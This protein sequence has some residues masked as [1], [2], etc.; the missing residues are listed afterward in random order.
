M[1]AGGASATLE[2]DIVSR[3]LLP[4]IASSVVLIAIAVLAAWAGGLI[5]AVVVAAI[6][7]VVHAEW[8]GV[9]E[10]EASAALPFTAAV[11]F[12][13][14]VFGLDYPTLAFVIAALGV[15]A[16]AAVGPRPWRPVGVLYALTLGLGLLVLRDSPDYGL[17]AIAVLV[18]VV[19]ATD[20]GAFVAGRSIGGP[21][22]WP[23][24][25]PKKTWA[26]A[27]GGLAAGIAAGIVAAALL[28][29]GVSAGLVAVIVILSI[30]SQWGDLFES[31]VKR[32]FGAKDSG[33]L[34]PG[35]GGMMDRVDGLVFASAVAVMIGIGHNGVAN[36]AQG[37]VVW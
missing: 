35:H 17:A 24:V 22:L 2:S 7:A 21:K 3:D 16:G 32:R 30:S 14:L 26:G 4:R 31:W 29:L 1:R 19:A 18:A 25:S 9:T 11:I 34:V 20:I 15:V 13:L 23:A 5:A 12:S 37:L 36:P 6:S 33:R 8:T 28:D 10:A 27:I